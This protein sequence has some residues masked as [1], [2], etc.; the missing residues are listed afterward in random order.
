MT[1]QEAVAPTP[2]Q[3]IGQ[4]SESRMTVPRR[5]H[6]TAGGAAMPV[7][8]GA[9]AVQS[10]P[11]ATNQ[12]SVTE[13]VVQHGQVITPQQAQDIANGFT[14][15]MQQRADAR[16]ASD[17]H[18]NNPLD[19][20]NRMFNPVAQQQP[21]QSSGKVNQAAEQVPQVTNL[22]GLAEALERTRKAVDDATESEEDKK[23]REKREKR[24]KL[25][26]TIGDGLGA[27]HEAYS[28]MMGQKP[29]TSGSLSAAQEARVE[30]LGLKR[31]KKYKDALDN[32]L[33]VIDMQRKNEYYNSLA[34]T[35]K[36]QQESLER[37]RTEKRKMQ[38]EKNQ[39]Y[40]NLQEAKRQNEL[41]KSDYYTAYLAALNNG[42]DIE[43]AKAYANQE[44]VRL[45]NERE[46]QEQAIA[47]AKE[48]S[49]NA[50]ASQSNAAANASN[51]RAAKTRA[52]GSSG[53]T[54]T[55]VSDKTEYDK[56]GNVK[57]RTVTKTTKS[58]GGSG[59]GGSSSSKKPKRKRTNVN[60]NK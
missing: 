2:Q 6:Q 42:A 58:K 34:E 14:Q 28:H 1:R 38:Q 60:W 22:A 30:A 15:Q 4:T 50:K 47:K 51:A 53:G 23:A 57:G 33:K 29:M 20:M 46:A 10:V 39:A 31:D 24:Q 17:R 36:A 9:T 11:A 19:P 45:A 25:L 18:Q 41:E 3:A 32:Y 52:G 40:I 5:T 55:T 7:R 12:A 21:Q 43:T 16:Q 49:Y 13:P 27:F 8:G 35:R 48:N 37:D 44:V 59:S 26:A 56:K 54:Y